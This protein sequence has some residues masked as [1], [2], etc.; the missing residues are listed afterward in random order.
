MSFA[1]AA[2]ATAT[3]AKEIDMFYMHDMGWDGLDLG[4]LGVVIQAWLYKHGYTG[5]G[6]CMYSECTI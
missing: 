2:A 6:S 4:V 1:A 5:M 3:A